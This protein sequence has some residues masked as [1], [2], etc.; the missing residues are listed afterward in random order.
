M[1]CV[2]CTFDDSECKKFRICGE[3]DSLVD[4]FFQDHREKL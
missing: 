3:C 2:I 4:S 1:K